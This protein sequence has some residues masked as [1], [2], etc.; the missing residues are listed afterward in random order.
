MK[1]EMEFEF[2]NDVDEIIEC[3]AVKWPDHMGMEVVLKSFYDNLSISCDWATML[4][5]ARTILDMYTE[6]TRRKNE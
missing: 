5:L 2:R 3:K 6:N 1:D 4:V